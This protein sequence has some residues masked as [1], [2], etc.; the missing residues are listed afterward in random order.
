MSLSSQTNVASLNAQ[1]NIRVNSSFQSSTIQRLSSGFRIN[2]SADDAAGLAVANRYRGDTS[3]LTQ[4]VLNANSGVSSL[5]IVDGGLNNISTILD[6]LRTLATQSASATFTGD[7]ATLNTEY[8]GLLA[9][10]NRQAANIK[11][12]TGGLFNTNL[13]TYVGGGGTTANSQVAV[14]LS[15]SN[16]AVDSA[17]LGISNT[18]VAG[19]GTQIAGN[20]IRLDDT[21]AVFLAGT[22]QSFTFHLNTGTGNQDITATVAGGGGGLSG[23]QVVANLNTALQA[24][25]ITASIGS[26]GT[27]QLGGTT[28][29]TVSTNAAGTGP[30]AATGTAVNSSNYSI[31][32]GPFAAFT[33]G[34]GV[35][36]T[37]TF[38]V[39][40]AS[41]SYNINL[42]SLNADTLTGVLTTLNTALTGTGI[43]AVKS[44]SG[45]DV[46]L[47]SANAF[48]I[49]ETAFTAGSGGGTGSLFGTVGA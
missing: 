1:N 46:T 41:G 47:Q 4:G 31:D 30:V 27:L 45:T 18:S 33:T 9:E 42:T 37:E 20:T 23:A 24:Y 11:L 25:G 16:N 39:Q 21:A 44:S 17:A 32:S 49:N 15:G 7:R 48:S 10:V 2:S 43:Y 36:A 29:F 38:V 14:D 19:G 34:G 5:Q 22:S 28:A 6:R 35:A 12:D 40:N 26:N 3:E 8:Q 13:I